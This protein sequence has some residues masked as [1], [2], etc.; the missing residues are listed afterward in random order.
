MFV[1]VCVCVCVYGMHVFVLCQWKVWSV[2]YTAPGAA[3]VHLQKISHTAG[4]EKQNI[5]QGIPK[6]LLQ[7]FSKIRERDPWWL[8]VGIWTEKEA[9]KNETSKKQY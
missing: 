4:S 5:A 1:C 2:A 7:L 8:E 9:V 3:A 6:E